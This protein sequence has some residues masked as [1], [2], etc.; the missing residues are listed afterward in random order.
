MTVERTTKKVTKLSEYHGK[1][2]RK[3]LR[4][5][6]REE[7]KRELCDQL[8]QVPNIKYCSMKL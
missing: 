2:S 5:T 1:G 6:R 4:V 3:N 7:G 8:H